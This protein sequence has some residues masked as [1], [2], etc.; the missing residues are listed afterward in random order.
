MVGRNEES[1]LLK[2]IAQADRSQ[3]RFFLSSYHGNNSANVKTDYI[4][5]LSWLKVNTGIING[6]YLNKSY[7]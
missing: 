1:K 4:I 3:L 7:R 2:K 5:A 6:L